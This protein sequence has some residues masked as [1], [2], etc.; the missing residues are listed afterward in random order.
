MLPC[1][2]A[3]PYSEYEP[4]LAEAPMFCEAEEEVGG[5]L[6]TWAGWAE[7]VLELVVLLL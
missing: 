1:R 6:L 3:V 4:G 5:A 2:P 7:L